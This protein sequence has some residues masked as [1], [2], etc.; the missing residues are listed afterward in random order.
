M[1]LEGWVFHENPWWAPE[2]QAVKFVAD[3]DGVRHICA[4]SRT[5]LN[6]YFKTEDTSEAALNNYSA[7]A[8]MVHSLAVRLIEEGILK[9]NGCVFIT[10]DM[11]KKYWP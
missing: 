3:N 7:H 2:Y 1:N 10:L 8:E 9:N 4:I 6:D 5:A 11:C